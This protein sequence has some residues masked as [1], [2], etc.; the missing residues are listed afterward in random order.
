MIEKWKMEMSMTCV[1]IT[2]TYTLK[3]TKQ[4][5]TRLPISIKKMPSYFLK[6]YSYN[7]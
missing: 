6:I 5:L 4:G 7:L 3:W 2:Y 1:I